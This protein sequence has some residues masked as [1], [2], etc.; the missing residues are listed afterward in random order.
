MKAKEKKCV[1]FILVFYILQKQNKI[2]PEQNLLTF[3]QCPLPGSVSVFYNDHSVA[4]IQ[5][6][7]RPFYWYYLWW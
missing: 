5:E 3:Y 2:K 1:A 7:T 6:F 4:P